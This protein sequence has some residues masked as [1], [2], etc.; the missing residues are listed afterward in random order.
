MKM[1][2][3]LKI[4]HFGDTHGHHRKLSPP[5]VDIAIFSGDAGTYRDPAMNSIHVKDFLEWF[6]ELNIPIKI[7]IAGNHDSSIEHRLIWKSD[8]KKAGII[9]LEHE[10]HVLEYKGQTITIFGSPYTPSFNN[11]SFNKARHKLHLFWDQIPENVDILVTHGPPMGILDLT[12]NQQK[13]YELCGCANLRKQIVGRIQ[14]RFHLFGHIHNHMNEV[15]AN[16]GTKTIPQCRT[17]FSNGAVCED[18][19]MSKASYNGNILTYT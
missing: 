2:N 11:W 16:S 4:W 13:S 12:Y 19:R 3:N 18:G 5:D 15:Y 10:L 7:M 9:Y 1:S 17:M 14:P 8:F 6:G